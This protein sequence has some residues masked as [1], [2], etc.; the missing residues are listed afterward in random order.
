[1]RRTYKTDWTKLELETIESESAPYRIL[2]SI[3]KIVGLLIVIVCAY[4]HETY[5]KG[6]YEP[7]VLFL[8]L[9]GVLIMIGGLGISSIGWNKF[10]NIK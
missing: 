5:S 6:D 3:A 4:W 2:G 9:A 1:M 8:A 7:I 10:K